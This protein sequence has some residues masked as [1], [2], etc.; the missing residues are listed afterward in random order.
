M[1]DKAFFAEYILPQPLV[2]SIGCFYYCSHALLIK[3]WKHPNKGGPQQK[4][5][6]DVRLILYPVVK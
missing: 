4:S 2:T 1:K 6:W 3:N 5:L